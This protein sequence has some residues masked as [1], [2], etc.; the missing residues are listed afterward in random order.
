MLLNVYLLGGTH[1]EGAT[2][3]NVGFSRRGHANEKRAL[4]LAVPSANGT[5]TD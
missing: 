5:P 2:V 4:R 1:L 3:R